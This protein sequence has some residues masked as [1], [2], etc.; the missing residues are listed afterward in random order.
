MGPFF[1]SELCSD[2]LCCWNAP[3]PGF[4][5]ILASL[6]PHFCVAARYQ[7]QLFFLPPQTG[8]AKISNTRGGVLGNTFLLQLTRKHSLVG[9]H[10][11]PPNWG[12]KFHFLLLSLH[13]F[14]GLFL[15][16]NWGGGILHFWTF[17]RKELEFIFERNR[18]MRPI[19]GGALMKHFSSAAH[20]ET[21]SGGL[22]LS[23]KHF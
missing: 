11:P 14:G 12:G 9:P 7:E 10:P 8:G 6:F 23:T 1:T 21:L 15:P 16:P 2:L 22:P 18:K 13:V 17:S 4:F 5:I 3:G 19:L 20:S